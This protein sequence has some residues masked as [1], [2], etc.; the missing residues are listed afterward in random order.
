M[1]PLITIHFLMFPLQ[2][3]Q[4]PR[5]ATGFKMSIVPVDRSNSWYLR[6]YFAEP[7][8]RV[9]KGER[10][11]N[12]LLGSGDAFNTIG[13]SPQGFDILSK[14]QPLSPLTVPIFFNFSAYAQVSPLAYNSLIG[15]YPERDE[16]AVCVNCA[17]LPQFLR[18]RP[19]ESP[20]VPFNTL[21]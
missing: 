6:Y 11:F 16:S 21:I 5:G 1:F 7:N 3:L 15:V 8:P 20:I 17:R 18:L 19:S 10:V 9:K 2:I 4:G 12:V 14:T 13:T